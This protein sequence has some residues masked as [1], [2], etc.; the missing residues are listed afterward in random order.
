MSVELLIGCVL[1][2][3]ARIADVSL[4]TL[5]TLCVVSGRATLAWVLGFFEVLVWVLAVSQVIH[6]LE[7]PAYILA[8]CMGYATGNYVGVKLDQWLAWGNQIVRVFTAEA[9]ATAAVLR[10]EGYVVTE[11]TGAGPDGPVSMLFLES[12]RKFSPRVL[13]HVATIDP[14]C[15]YFVDDIRAV[16]PTGGAFF[17]PSGWRA[18]L[19]KK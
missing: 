19:K 12:R 5:R 10:Q 8:Y 16:K 13:R 2:F 1:I 7:S 9:A 11:F 18:V 6:N 14:Q 4:G 3:L 17:Q 15:T